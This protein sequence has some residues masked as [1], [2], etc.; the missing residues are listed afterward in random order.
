MNDIVLGSA[1]AGS[2]AAAKRRRLNAKERAYAFEIF[3]DSIDYDAVEISRRSIFALATA[4]TIG[5]S[6]N[7]RAEHFARGTFDL[8]EA[9]W[10]VLIHELGH[11][12]QFQNGGFRYVPSSLVAQFVAWIKTGTRRTAYDWRRADSRGWPWGKWNAEQQAQFLSDYNECLRRT[13]RGDATGAD[14]QTL[15]LALPYIERVRRCEG[16]PGQA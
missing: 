6:I 5:N 12:W 15:S 8:S 16:A 7:L 1:G 10:F 4:T 11:V 3:S 9:G 2:Q 13:K 14:R